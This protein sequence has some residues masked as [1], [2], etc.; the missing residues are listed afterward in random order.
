MVMVEFFRNGAFGTIAPFLAIFILEDIVGGSP[1][2]AGFAVAIF[3]TVKS[4]FQLPIAKWLDKTDGELDEFW[5]LFIG[6]LVVAFVPLIYFFATQPWHIYAAQVLFGFA[7][8]WAV[9]AWYS[10]FTRHL[11]TFRIGFEWSLFSV[12]SIGASTAIGAASAG[13]LIENFGFRVI[14]LVASIVIFLAALGVLG[15][16]KHI[17]PKRDSLEKIMPEHKHHKSEI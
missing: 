12:F 17:F 7:A 4:I 8:A 9:P 1:H 6:Y 13:L 14:F 5:A 3:W 2:V 16:K 11:D 15:I 10:I